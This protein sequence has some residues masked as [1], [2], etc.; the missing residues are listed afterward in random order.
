[1]SHKLE[2]I[3]KLVAEDSPRGNTKIN[4]LSMKHIKIFE[5][6]VASTK[7]VVE[8]AVTFSK[9]TDSVSL[10]LKPTYLIK[11]KQKLG[12]ENNEE[13]STERIKQF[14]KEKN[15]EET[16]ILN[17]A[18]VLTAMKGDAPV[19]EPSTQT[20]E[21]VPLGESPISEPTT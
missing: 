4:N 19:D 20:T 9:Q 10:S 7:K 8:S 6:F 2:H 18:T 16:G 11:I 21:D 14:Q 15:M 3:N 1:M 5:E 12:I 13:I 17:H